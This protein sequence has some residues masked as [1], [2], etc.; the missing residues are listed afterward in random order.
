MLKND[1]TAGYSWAVFSFH[2]NETGDYAGRYAGFS[3]SSSEG[4]NAPYIEVT[5]V[6]EPAAMAT[7]AVVCMGLLRR[8]RSV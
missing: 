8:R 3:F 1:L 4:G 6:P 7:M 5:A 2:A